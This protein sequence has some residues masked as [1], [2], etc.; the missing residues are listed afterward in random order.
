MTLAEHLKELMNRSI[1]SLVSLGMLSGLGLLF[2]SNILE[3]LKLPAGSLMGQLIF[4]S[5]QDGFWVYMRIAFLCGVIIS[6]PIILY[7]AWAFIIPTLEDKAK[8]YRRLFIIF[9]SLFFILGCLFAYFVLIPPALK[10]FLG[11]GK[12]ELGPVISV[13]KYIS[14]TVSFILGCGLVF[15]MPA[16]SL[17]LSKAGIINPQILR[18]KYKYA[19]LIILILS[20]IITPTP[21]AFKVLLLACLMLFLYEVSIGVSFLAQPKVRR[22]GMR[23]I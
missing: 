15:Q 8:R 14:F 1:I 17:V 2:A 7:Q 6:M 18:R 16:L 19:I 22:Q 5:P 12:E 10:F 21:D 11:F 23:L 13:S 20:A 9:C 3:I 4:F